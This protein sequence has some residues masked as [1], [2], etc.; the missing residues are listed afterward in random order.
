[1]Q[2]KQEYTEY[3]IRTSS[4]SFSRLVSKTF[5]QATI[6][7]NTKKEEYRQMCYPNPSNM[8]GFEQ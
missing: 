6:I 5:N 2:I 1:M 4:L 7:C 8:N 3:E